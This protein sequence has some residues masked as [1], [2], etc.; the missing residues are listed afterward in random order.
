M[1]FAERLA[2]AIEHETGRRALLEPAPEDW[3]FLNEQSCPAVWLSIGW[4]EDE[5]E[6]S[7]LVDRAYHKQLGTAVALAVHAHGASAD[8]GD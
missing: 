7:L 2:E 6:E 4:F 3:F 5:E 1:R 8:E